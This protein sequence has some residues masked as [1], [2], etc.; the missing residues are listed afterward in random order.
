MVGGG[1]GGNSP[2][3]SPDAAEAEKLGTLRTLPQLSTII[4]RRNKPVPS[5]F[6]RDTLSPSAI[7]SSLHWLY[8]QLV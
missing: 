6:G 3:I 4:R 2:W 7:N 5:G 1:G 8:Q